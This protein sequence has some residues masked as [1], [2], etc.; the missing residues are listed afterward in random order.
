M[1]DPS[2]ARVSGAWIDDED[3]AMPTARRVASITQI[4]SV[5]M[6]QLKSAKW[7]TTRTSI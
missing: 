2:A 3:A 4:V 6:S 7:T 5:W 1:F